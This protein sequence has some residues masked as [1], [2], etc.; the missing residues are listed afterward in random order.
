MQYLFVIFSFL[1]S[2]SL[3]AKSTISIVAE[4]HIYDDYL[5]LVKGREIKTINEYGGKCARREVTE[6]LLIQQMLALGGFDYDF[7]LEP[8][9]YAQK[10][11]K[12]LKSGMLLVGVDS[13]WSSQAKLL[14]SDVYITPALIEEGSYVAGLYTVEGNTK[15]LSASN[16]RKIKNLSIISSKTWPVDWQLIQSLGFSNISHEVSWMTQAKLMRAK[17][18]DVMLIPFSNEKDKSYVFLDTK[19]IPIPNVKVSF[20][21]G[22]HVLISKKH[23]LGKQAYKAFLK[24]MKIMKASGAIEKAFKQSG[25]TREDV[26]DWPSL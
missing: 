20:P 24:G 23:P 4:Q 25:L 22:R 2:V 9:Y 16:E 1:F 17:L 11:V 18:V 19:F 21:E 26:R 6:I 13:F 8:G 14:Q 3:S 10:D 5:C 15:A 7:E 12:L